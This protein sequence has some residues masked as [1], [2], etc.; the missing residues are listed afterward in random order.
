[1]IALLGAI[2]WPRLAA[3]F[4]EHRLKPAVPEDDSQ[5]EQFQRICKSAQRFEGQA[6]SLG[7]VTCPTSACVVT[8]AQPLFAGSSA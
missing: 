1:M 5:L 4:I 8:A 2:V 7:Y 3:S 6:A